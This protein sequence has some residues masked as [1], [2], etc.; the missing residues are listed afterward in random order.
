MLPWAP[1]WAASGVPGRIT[2]AR[3]AKSRSWSSTQWNVAVDSTA[4]T[5]PPSPRTPGESSSRSPS[6]KTTLPAKRAKRWRA[7]TSIDG[8]ASKATTLP[9][10]RRCSNISV[11]RPAPRGCVENP[12]VATQVQAAEHLRAPARG[13]GSGDAVVG[14]RVP[15]RVGR[16]DVV[17]RFAARPRHVRGPVPLRPSAILGSRLFLPE[18]RVL[19]VVEPDAG[20][21]AG[22]AERPG[23]VGSE[24]PHGSGSCQSCAHSSAVSA[25]SAV[26]GPGSSSPAVDSSTP[27]PSPAADPRCTPA[28]RRDH[29]SARRGSGRLV[30]DDP[31]SCTNRREAPT[32]TG[33]GM[34]WLVEPH[35]VRLHAWVRYS[36]RWHV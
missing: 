28:R 2:A 30:H 3:L 35:N 31:T 24:S 13:M 33:W 32:G 25:V 23:A 16:G 9:V 8:A 4:S 36:C 34:A 12:F 5:G 17:V 7:S 27:S 15:V 26:S 10:G 14:R 21:R 11:T 20:R 1:H 19:E 29:D 6:T 22:G 18:A